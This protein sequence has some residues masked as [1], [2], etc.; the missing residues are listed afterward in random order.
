MEFPVN[1]KGNQSWI[2]IGST[3]SEAEV[4]IFW[5]PDMKSHLMSKGPDDGKD[6]GQ[7]EKGTTE[8]EMVG[9]H[10]QVDGHEF[11]QLWGDG[12]GQGSLPSMGSQRVGY[13]WAT[14]QQQHTH[15]DLQKKMSTCKTW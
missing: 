7:E 4:P 13:N 10:R 6:W 3:D 12:E 8:D 2:V 5:A 14:E 11:E 15:R 1:P 9:W